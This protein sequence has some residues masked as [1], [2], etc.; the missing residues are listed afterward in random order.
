MAMMS[1]TMKMK[2]PLSSS[3]LNKMASFCEVVMSKYVVSLPTKAV[4][5]D[6]NTGTLLSSAATHGA[7]RFSKKIKKG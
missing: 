5:V 2:R 3:Q 7:A 4:A 6:Q 1:V